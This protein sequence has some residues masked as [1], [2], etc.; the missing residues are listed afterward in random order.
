MK[1]T[2][3]N[4]CSE[5]LLLGMDK[6]IHKLEI[7]LFYRNDPTDKYIHRKAMFKRNLLTPI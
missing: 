5:V 4:A 3:S 2:K 7:K 6:I 1:Q